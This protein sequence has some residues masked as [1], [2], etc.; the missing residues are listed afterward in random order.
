MSTAT[1]IAQSLTGLLAKRVASQGDEPYIYTSSPEST[2]LLES[3]TYACAFTSCPTASAD[4]LLDFSYSDVQRAVDRLAWH[5]SSIGLASAVAPGE[6][7]PQQVIAVLT[8]SSFDESLL[9][10][11]LAKL[12]LAP[13]L[14]SVNNS[15][16]AIAHLCQKTSATH[17]I[18]GPKFAEAAR[19]SQALLK[20]QNCP[21]EL[22]PDQRFP[23]W[24]KDGARACTVQPFQA[25]LTPEQESM[26]TGVILHSSGSVSSLLLRS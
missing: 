4:F 11:A 22:V 10:M 26:R 24:G 23:L 1:F 17:L 3:L 8:S 9:E 5:Y 2:Q 6:L 7:P 13:L 15:V 14:L 20:E 19:E 18:Y 16:A 12:A 21:I 25:V